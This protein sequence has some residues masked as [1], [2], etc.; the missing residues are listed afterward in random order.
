MFQ[1]FNFK[2]KTFPPQITI[3]LSDIL[4]LYPLN[5]KNKNIKLK[6]IHPTKEWRKNNAE[7]PKTRSTMQFLQW[8]G[9]ITIHEVLC[10]NKFHHENPTIFSNQFVPS[11]WFLLPGPLKKTAILLKDTE[12]RTYIMVRKIIHVHCIIQSIYN[13]TLARPIVI[14]VYDS[15]P[16]N[17]FDL[18]VINYLISTSTL[19]MTSNACSFSTPKTMTGS[20]EI[21]LQGNNSL[22]PLVGEELQLLLSL[23]CFFNLVFPWS[24]F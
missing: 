16:F 10:L 7:G 6:K 8:F 12:E 4:L 24:K 18:Y 15:S 13:F 2:V 20:S 14:S 9:F 3:E 1:K 11:F 22:L 23:L 19:S 5:S 21:L 17:F